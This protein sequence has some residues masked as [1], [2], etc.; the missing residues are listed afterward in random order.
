VAVAVTA[1][2]GLRA[3]PY[4][5]YAKTILRLR[6]LDGLDAEPSHAWRGT[7]VHAI[8]EAWHKQGAPMGQLAATAHGVL[9]AM[10]AHPLA[11]GLWRPRLMA[12]L[13]WIDAEVA[14]LATQGRVVLASEARGELVMDGIRLHG[15][16]D[17]IDRLPDGTLGIVDYKTGMA[18]SAAKVAKGFA[19]Q[20]GLLGLIAR[21][22]GFV[23]GDG[24]RLAGEPTVF[25]YWSFGKNGEQFGMRKQP[26]AGPRSKGLAVEE[27]VDVTSDFLREAIARWLLGNEPF[28]AMLRPDMV[29]Y[30]DYDQVMRLDEW[31]GWLGDEANGA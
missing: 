4:G 17:R 10:S 20:L 19:L 21:Q 31:I 22:G 5:F 27:F 2:D 18:P 25:E 14:E 29:G 3:D 9:D 12:A 26:L 30:N 7:A 23:G 6:K 1:L 13:E 24:T 28:T 8:L 16:A 11:R 15:R